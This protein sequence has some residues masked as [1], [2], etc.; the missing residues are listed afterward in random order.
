MF[1]LGEKVDLIKLKTESDQQED[2]LH[3]INSYLTSME[4][5][6]IKSMALAKEDDMAVS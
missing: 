1:L 6:L 5:G 4:A 2:I 3:I